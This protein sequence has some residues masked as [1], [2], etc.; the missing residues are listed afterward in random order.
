MKNKNIFLLTIT[1][2]VLSFCTASSYKFSTELPVFAKPA[3]ENATSHQV[4]RI[5]DCCTIVADINNQ[6]VKIKLAALK[7]AKAYS[8]QAAVFV[9]NLLKGENVYI[10]GDPNEKYVYRAPDGLF[11]NAEIIR[12]GYGRVDTDSE[13]AYLAEFKQ[14]Q[15]FAKERNK[16][17]WNTIDIVPPAQAAPSPALP[18][19]VVT[20]PQAKD[21]D[22]IVYVTKSGT[23][24]HLAN[25]QH[26]S[27]SSLPIKLQDAK[28]RGYTPCSRCSPP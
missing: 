2:T 4:V 3:F 15:A 16:G 20:A 21:E 1:I 24:Y 17:L 13:S 11:V 28:A 12:Q 9:G 14:L 10:L 23:K 19:P 22:I 8:E 18:V 5:I 7:P 6:E 27:Q 26:L 25:C